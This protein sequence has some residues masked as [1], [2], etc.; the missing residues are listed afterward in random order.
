MTSSYQP[1][2]ALSLGVDGFR[3]TCDGNYDIKTDIPVVGKLSTSGQVD[4]TLSV[5]I[6]VP[7]Q[8]LTNFTPGYAHAV[9][10]S[11]TTTQATIDNIEF[12][13]S[14]W[15]P[16]ILD[17]FK[18]AVKI[19]LPPLLDPKVNGIVDG[20]VVRNISH[21]LTQVAVALSR[22]AH[23][24][25][26][27]PPNLPNSIDWT[28]TRL[29]SLSHTLTGLIK[30]GYLTIMRTM[31]NGTGIMH[32]KGPRL[33]L[34][35]VLG[36]VPLLGYNFSIHLRD[37]VIGG[38]DTVVFEKVLNP[39]DSYF[40][41][42]S[43]TQDRLTLWI[44]ATMV[45]VPT[46][47]NP[48]T[49][50]T[51]LHEQIILSM[52]L[53]NISL[54]VRLFA[55]IDKESVK[56][57]TVYQITQ[58]GC[59]LRQPGVA[60]NIT[61]LNASFL[62]REVA[63]QMPTG[64]PAA[65]ESGIANVLNTIASYIVDTDAKLLQTHLTSLLDPLRSRISS[66]MFDPNRYTCRQYPSWTGPVVNWKLV[67]AMQK[68]SKLTDSVID[69]VLRQLFPD[70]SATFNWTRFKFS[71][72]PFSTN[73]TLRP[74]SFAFESGIADLFNTSLV[75][76]KSPYLISSPRIGVGLPRPLA[77]TFRTKFVMATLD[78]TC[79]KS[80]DMSAR[81]NVSQ[82]HLALDLFLS[83]RASIGNATI[84]SLDSMGPNTGACVAAGYL[85]HINFTLS[86]LT[87]ESL[88]SWI[89]VDGGPFV[90]PTAYLAQT[91]PTTLRV[92]NGVLYALPEVADRLINAQLAQA[93][94]SAPRKCKGEIT[95]NQDPSTTTNVKTPWV[96]LLVAVGCLLVTGA[97]VTFIARK[98]RNANQT[99]ISTQTRYT[100]LESEAIT[101]GSQ[102]TA[103]IKREPEHWQEQASG[104]FQ[105]HD[106]DQS[107]WGLRPHNTNTSHPSHALRHRYKRYEAL[108][109]I[110][111]MLMIANLGVKCWA[112]MVKVVQVRL[113]VGL[114]PIGH[115]LMDEYVIDFT[116]GKMLE[117]FWKSKGLP[118]YYFYFPFV[119]R[120]LTCCSAMPIKAYL[121]AF[122]IAFGTCVLPVVKSTLL[123]TTWFVPLQGQTRSRLLHTLAQIGKGSYIDIMFLTYI[124]LITKQKMTA[125][126]T[127]TI[128]ITSEPVQG[129]FGG[130][131][132][133]TVNII[134][135]HVLI[136]L[137]ENAENAREDLTV[138]SDPKSEPSIGSRGPIPSLLVCFV[139]CP[140]QQK[141]LLA[142]VT[143][144]VHRKDSIDADVALNV[145]GTVSREN[146]PEPQVALQGTN[147]KKE[148]IPTGHARSSSTHRRRRV[149]IAG[150]ALLAPLVI[151]PLV[152]WFETC[153][154]DISGMAAEYQN[155]LVK[156]HM[157]R[158]ESMATELP[159]STDNKAS[160]YFVACVF[161][162]LVL[163]LPL[164]CTLLFL[165]LWV[166][167][168]N[169]VRQQNRYFTTL[170]WAFSYQ[171]FDVFWIASLAA[172]LE[173]NLVVTYI[174]TETVSSLCRQ[175]NAGTACS[176]LSKYLGTNDIMHVEG[177]PLAGFYCLGAASLALAFLFALTAAARSK[178]RAFVDG[179]L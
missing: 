94:E 164:M 31:T 50:S 148:F 107:S 8:I 84:R 86:E 80:Y 36:P 135:C 6:T 75:L 63:I 125:M 149:L 55:G 83:L 32:I 3:L 87:L 104:E 59:I 111:P 90:Q 102:A 2:N 73:M 168:T 54:G 114:E 110:L 143:D 5:S 134:L 16:K 12:S 121:I 127:V 138:E 26:V 4:V 14:G 178:A 43:F 120:A 146:T 108:Q 52:R 140:P 152:Y 48:P 18:G 141:P 118:L 82:L 53:D 176:E 95:P 49:G 44:N 64:G 113:Q 147:E 89:R 128:E 119:V 96:I 77:S 144:D 46:S 92:M 99:T 167:T 60:F 105:E 155:V 70:D 166:R 117:Y 100:S 171:S 151:I 22:P 133:T 91:S 154:F 29:K 30:N 81:V 17:A 172:I 109:W 122:L 153:S 115:V 28:N 136:H 177:Q 76:V 165:W 150:F 173:T 35:P 157:Y 42:T 68:L 65:I 112:L 160:A 21:I 142:L 132:A 41:D 56:N 57:L 74:V 19:A 159:K 71:L 175:A 9:A 45:G 51:D 34:L 145:A 163:A 169:T 11:Q 25:P 39:T 179:A 123:L 139:S 106:V 7:M 88:R 98:C 24:P 79:T 15:T 129:I 130:I 47:A 174:L 126:G 58:P 137:N 61:Q 162:T 10:T 97:G 124:V 20:L 38:L 33:D 78:G 103:D 62:I 67:P 85:D 37:V 116:F 72:F 101:S 66:R 156:T 13:G 40:V 23:S 69:P 131:L 158:I 170:L 161:G 1:P 27:E 93:L